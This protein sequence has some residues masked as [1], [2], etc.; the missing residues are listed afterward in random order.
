MD[1]HDSILESQEELGGP[2]E[3]GTRALL[4]VNESESTLSG[5]SSVELCLHSM[6]QE[7]ALSRF[8]H[9]QKW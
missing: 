6:W 8:N 4:F 7:L 3:T 5:T 2:G 1:V 9:A